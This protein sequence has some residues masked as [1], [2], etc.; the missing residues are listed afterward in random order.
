MTTLQACQALD[1]QDALAPLHRHFT[2]PEGLIYLDGNSLGAAPAASRVAEVLQRE[3]A[4][5]LIRSWNDAGWIDLPQRL[6]NQLAPLIGAGPGKV[7]CTDSTSI[8]LYKVLSAALRCTQAD[9]PQ[10]TKLLSERSNFPTDPC[11]SPRACAVSTVWSWC[12]WSPKTSLLHCKTTWR[13]ACSRMSTTAPAP[14]MA[15]PPSL[16]PRTLPAC[17][18]CGPGAQRRRRAG[19]PARGVVGDFRQGDGGAGRHK[20][21]LRFGFTPLYLGFAEVWHAVEHLRQVLEH[22]EWQRPAFH[23]TQ[24]VT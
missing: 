17:W 8:N 15:W 20:D 16:R 22:G 13:C 21:I 3:W 18:W 4:Q 7:V 9:A 2:L 24:A 6:G 5:G 23:Q 11:T 10:R 12:C 1:A 14:C 19:G